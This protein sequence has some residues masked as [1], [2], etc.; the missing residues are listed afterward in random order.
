MKT[1]APSILKPISKSSWG[2]HPA[3]SSAAGSVGARPSATGSK[4]VLQR[5]ATGGAPSCSLCS[6]CASPALSG[7]SSSAFADTSSAWPSLSSLASSPSSTSSFSHN[8]Q[9]IQA[10]GQKSL[11]AKGT[12][13]RGRMVA[14]D[15][16]S[17]IGRQ[18]QQ[19]QATKKETKL[20]SKHG[21]SK[22]KKGAAAL[23]VS[24][25]KGVKLIVPSVKSRAIL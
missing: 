13:A 25:G 21:K 7:A 9:H 20:V 12:Q 10:Q 18:Q 8:G 23:V 15:A 11:R 24:K 14:L 6:S 19:Q 16:L 17:R 3:R 2:V 4:K 5:G 1:S 22:S